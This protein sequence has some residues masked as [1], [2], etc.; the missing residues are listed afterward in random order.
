MVKVKEKYFKT[1]YRPVGILLKYLRYDLLQLEF[2]KN[3]NF[4]YICKCT[5][6]LTLKIH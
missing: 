4:C 2:R 5:Y 1:K 6:S 3:K